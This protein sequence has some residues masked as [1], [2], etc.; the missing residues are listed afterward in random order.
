MSTIKANI[1]KRRISLTRKVESTGTKSSAVRAK[2]L[3]VMSGRWIGL[4]GR[5]RWIK[6]QQETPGTWVFYAYFYIAIL[7]LQMC[8][9]CAYYHMCVSWN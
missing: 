3:S 6:L 5:Q 4:S 7:L 9:K 2:L 1:E 8:N